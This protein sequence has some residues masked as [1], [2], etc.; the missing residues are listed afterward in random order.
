MG[1][2][3]R[4]EGILRKSGA[5]EVFAIVAHLPPEMFNLP[6]LARN[7]VTSRLYISMD[8]ALPFRLF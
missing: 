3:H 1:R 4:S 2:H 6:A 5:L 8:S 7:L